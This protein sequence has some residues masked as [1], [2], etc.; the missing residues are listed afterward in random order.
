MSGRFAKS[1]FATTALAI[2]AVS[3]TSFALANIPVDVDADMPAELPIESSALPASVTGTGLFG[4]SEA[5]LCFAEEDVLAWLD[6]E[7]SQ[8]GGEAVTLERGF[9]QDFSDV[10][11]NETSLAPV[12]VSGVYA[13]IFAN[14]S[15][16]EMVDVVELGQDGCAI[17]RTLLSG[18]EWRA[19]LTRA[20][21]VSV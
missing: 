10:W 14:A 2:V 7:R 9:D 20:A 12:T 13:H 6:R 15:G 3:A 4:E 1:T 21:G 18:E 11:R 17:S 16:F 19:L 8:I 5:P